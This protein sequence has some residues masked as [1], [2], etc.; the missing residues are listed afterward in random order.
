MRLVVH[1]LAALGLF[2]VGAAPNFAARGDS[3]GHAADA[4]VQIAQAPIP[5]I[6]LPTL[7]VPVG[8]TTT[9]VPP[10]TTT[11]TTAVTTTTTVSGCCGF[12]PTKLRFETVTGSG[13]SLEANC[14]SR[15]ATSRW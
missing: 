14:M 3:F 5:T 15:P 4:R 7:P 1:V 9:T 13:T 11:T 8:T 12:G 6:T 2:L 10:S